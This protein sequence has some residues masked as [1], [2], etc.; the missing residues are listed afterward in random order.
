[1]TRIDVL[2]DEVL[3][4]IFEL[5]LKMMNSTLGSRGARAW[6]LLIHVCR[7]WRNLVFRSPRRLKLRL[8]CTPE[9]PARKTLVVWPSLASY[10]RRRCDLIGIQ[11]HYIAWEAQSRMSSLPQAPRTLAFGKCLGRDA[12]TIP[13]VDRAEAL[14][15]QFLSANHSRFVLGRIRPTSAMLRIV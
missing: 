13:G 15:R 11:R 2:P 3:L 9:T 4:E 8:Y 10:H 12:G 6:K 5:N 14:L 1:M 7:R